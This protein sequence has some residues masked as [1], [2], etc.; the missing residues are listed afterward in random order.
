MVNNEFNNESIVVKNNSYDEVL[1]VTIYY[2]KIALR[3]STDSVFVAGTISAIVM[4]NNLYLA[5]FQNIRQFEYCK[6]LRFLLETK[7]I[8]VCVHGVSKQYFSCHA[9]SSPPPPKGS[10]PA[11]LVDCDKHKTLSTFRIAKCLPPYC[12]SIILI[13]PVFFILQAY[14]S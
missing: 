7:K 14:K 11:P 6:L 8:L 9:L 2:H 3:S 13:Y 1:H 5:R 12:G 4:Q 10:S